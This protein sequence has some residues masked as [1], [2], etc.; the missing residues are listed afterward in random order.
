MQ[1]FFHYLNPIPCPSFATFTN[2]WGGQTPGVSK[3]SV[4][5]LRN[6]GE[7][8]WRDEYSRLVAYVMLLGQYLT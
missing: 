1:P 3:L 2:G 8:I 5:A 7:R 4:G 6:K